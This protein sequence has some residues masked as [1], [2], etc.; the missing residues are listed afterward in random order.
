M[1]CVCR[2]LKCWTFVICVCISLQRVAAN[3]TDH[4]AANYRPLRINYYVNGY[5]DGHRTRAHGYVSSLYTDRE[6]YQGNVYDSHGDTSRR[7]QHTE[8]LYRDSS[9][10]VDAH[11]DGELQHQ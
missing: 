11:N 4:S 8:P 10:R 2:V 5:D 3:K 1:G 6:P 9:T 7:R